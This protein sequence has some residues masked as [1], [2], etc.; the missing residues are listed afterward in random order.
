M[1]LTYLALINKVLRKLREDQ[2]GTVSSTEYTSL[3][4][5]FV[6]DA[7]REVEDAWEWQCLRTEVTF[8]S[9]IGTSTYN[10]ATVN[11]RSKLAMD[12]CGRPMAFDTTSGSEIQLCLVGQDYRDNQRKLAT[13]QTNTQP[14]HFSLSTDG[15]TFTVNFLDTPSEVRTYS[16]YFFI[17]QDDLSSASTVMTIPWKPVVNLAHLYALDERGEEIGE[18]G[19]KAWL[20]YDNSLSDAIALDAKYSGHKLQWVVE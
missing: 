2:V 6:N 16:F 5:E 15:A 8:T 20:R 18:P 3:I 17:P 14:Y 9:V 7:K 19:S 1:Q 12:E 4:G 13:T 10:L 11:E